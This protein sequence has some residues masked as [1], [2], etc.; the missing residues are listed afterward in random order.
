MPKLAGQRPKLQRPDRADKESKLGPARDHFAARRPSRLAGTALSLALLIAP[1]TSPSLAENEDETSAGTPDVY[2]NTELLERLATEGPA[3]PPSAAG[4]PQSL[5]QTPPDWQL[6]SRLYV[7]PLD[8]S[9]PAEP[10]LAPPAPSILTSELKAL[11]GGRAQPQVRKEAPPVKPRAAPPRPAKTVVA[12]D[13]EVEATPPAAAES[14]ASQ[15]P[16]TAPT[17]PPSKAETPPTAPTQVTAELQSGGEE[18]A[19]DTPV[20]EASPPE[21]QA[22]PRA[23]LPTEAPSEVEAPAAAPPEITAE[24]QSRGEEAGSDKAGSQV[25]A[26]EPPK[27][28]PAAPPPQAPD[29]IDIPAIKPPSTAAAAPD[30]EPELPAAAT[31][32]DAPPPAAQILDELA[33]A[34]EREAPKSRRIVAPPVP[35]PPP[36]LAPDAEASAKS[37]ATAELAPA[38]PP[39]P[40]PEERL[41]PAPASPTTGDTEPQL[42]ARSPAQDAFEG[43][44]LFEAGSTELSPE[45]RGVLEG[46]AERLKAADAEGVELRAY[47]TGKDSRRLSLN[48]GLVA[49]SY[50][51]KLGVD[52]DSVF[53]RP[54][55]DK[56]TDGPSERIDFELVTP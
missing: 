22:A 17:E 48:R 6:E 33:E 7:V 42:A 41:G 30:P 3:E 51:E 9:G 4:P 13:P 45:A 28:A 54:L 29:D 31:G 46:L 8:Q 24:L 12:R 37:A 49:R 20:P 10:A 43:R 27:A 52:S 25:L 53:L 32:S 38:A 21:V 56:S 50:L 19:S 35:E 1:A 47:A 18:V 16:S 26:P 14:Q 34:A 39:A 44:I 11:E 40:N 36:P 15:T 55:G 23:P 2:V 5:L